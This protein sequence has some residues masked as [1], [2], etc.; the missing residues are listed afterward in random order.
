M[1][2]LFSFA[3][4]N[5]WRRNR[6]RTALTILAVA[7]ATVVF[8]IVMV[9][10]FVMD[11]IASIA[12][13]SPR[14]VVMNKTALR[15]GL[16]ESYYQKIVK[17]PDVVAVNRMVWFAGVYNSP[18]N[19][20]AS[21]AIDVDNP[22][23][24]WPEYGLDTATIAAF[25]THRDGALV[26]S[27][28]MHRFGWK[29]GQTVLLKSQRYPLTLAFQIVGTYD[30]G[31]DPTVFMFRRDYLEEALHNTGRVEFIWVRC[32]D[33][34]A[35]NRIAY[36]IDSTFRN[37]GDETETDTE[38]EFLVTFL[39]RFQS[40]GRMVQAVGLCAVFAIGL[41]VLNGAA[42][43]LRERRSEIAVLRTVGFVDSQIIL[44]FVCEA[45]ITALTGGI[46]GTLAATL[47]L[48]VARGAVPVLGPALSVGM[49]YPIMIGGVAMALVIGVVSAVVPTIAALRSPVYE[50]LRQIA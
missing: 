20:F 45:I 33:S 3:F 2:S 6:R 11:R 19:Q 24:I 25:K 18:R 8:C 36:Q 40:L 31:P 22:D 27:A 16:P 39:V 21:V 43:T 50:S 4:V 12:E 37:S 42:M 44:S 13:T 46:L 26:G 49:P 48:N 5:V 10:P 17:I 35:A 23:I 14:L 41:A 34:V 47:A 28:T 9:L 38:K 29:V 30:G 1:F 32:S 15:Y 7:C